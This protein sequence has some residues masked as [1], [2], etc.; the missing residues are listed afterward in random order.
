MTT[1]H[2]PKMLLALCAVI[3][4]RILRFRTP[5]RRDLNT[6]DRLTVAP[7]QL[8]IRSNE[9]CRFTSVLYKEQKL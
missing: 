4:A 8:Q 7:Q 5:R 3:A 1:I 6:I 9:L 2:H